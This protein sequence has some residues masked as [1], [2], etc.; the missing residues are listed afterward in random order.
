MRNL[1]AWLTVVLILFSESVKS[2]YKVYDKSRNVVLSSTGSS[3]TTLNELVIIVNGHE[4]P[5]SLLGVPVD[6]LRVFAFIDTQLKPITFQIDELNESGL[7]YCGTGSFQ[8]K[9]RR[10]GFLDKHDELLLMLSDVGVKALTA[11]FLQSN[12]PDIP[13]D[14]IEMVIHIE[15]QAYRVY[16]T[17]V[18]S[19]NIDDSTDNGVKDYVAFDPVSGTVF[20]KNFRLD[21]NIDDYSDIESFQ[22]IQKNQQLSE[23]L[24]VDYRF[25]I[26]TGILT[27]LLRVKVNSQ[28]HI[29]A[30][31]LGYKDGPIRVSLLLE[32]VLRWG[33]MVLYKDLIVVDHYK[34]SVKIPAR[35]T[36]LRYRTL[37]FFAHLLKEPEIQ[38]IGKFS[39][40]IGTKVTIDMANSKAM[41]IDVDG[42]SSEGEGLLDNLAF[43]ARWAWIE[44]PS[45]WRIF[46]NNTMPVAEDGLI[47]HYLSG[48]DFSF[49]YDELDE[50]EQSTVGMTVKGLP[51]EG[52]VL[53]GEISKIPL[54]EIDNFQQLVNAVIELDVDKKLKKFDKLNRR[55]M[56]EVLT[57]TG[58]ENPVKLTKM[59]I[60]DLDRMNLSIHDRTDFYDLILEISDS[61][62]SVEEMTLGEIA[63]R[64]NEG[65]K[66]RKLPL[67][68][69]SLDFIENSLWFFSQ[70]DLLPTTLFGM[71]NNIPRRDYRFMH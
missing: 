32:V 70:E 65:A 5:K 36:A 58:Y 30:K 40:I 44:G 57:H 48:M 69:I 18:S 34:N 26:Q 53:L 59:L 4:L 66:A 68:Q 15:Q 67:E 29:T 23:N 1:P 25:E 54:K 7:V 63:L 39:N 50:H 33:G 41:I 62:D 49:Y 31:L 52:I 45:N 2:E 20:S 61:F 64:L 35:S 16:L 22:I 56:T 19:G 10:L 51:T 13:S 47:I 11:Q 12:E 43:N 37:N 8:A 27:N 60:K 17:T 28:K 46:F 14:L 9:P 55:I 24:L 3:A 38:F 71:I 42:K 21:Y 6:Q